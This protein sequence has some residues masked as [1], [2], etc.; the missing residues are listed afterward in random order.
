MKINK[1]NEYISN[2]QRTTEY[3]LSIEN[4]KGEEKE[5]LIREWIKNDDYETENDIAF[6]D[7][8]GKEISE[9]EIRAFLGKDENDYSDD[10]DTLMD[11]I[12][13]GCP[14]VINKTEKLE[15]SYQKHLNGLIKLWKDGDTEPLDGDEVERL[16]VFIR[17]EINRIE[18]NN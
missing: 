7:K 4:S 5:I 2:I 10:Y 12:Q 9:E 14:E 8:L 3:N 6:S 11:Y 13:N 18:A 17:G 15:L 16:C 1:I